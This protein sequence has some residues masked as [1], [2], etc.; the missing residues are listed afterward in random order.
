[1]ISTE[2]SSDSDGE[3]AMNR[4]THSIDEHRL[5]THTTL[6][7]GRMSSM[8][9]TKFLTT[10]SLSLF[11]DSLRRWAYISCAVGKLGKDELRLFEGAHFGGAALVGAGSWA[12]MMILIR[13]DDVL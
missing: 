12:D 1:M 8:T 9:P 11:S 3:D 6:E 4:L 10:N 13:D 5:P 7:S 2:R